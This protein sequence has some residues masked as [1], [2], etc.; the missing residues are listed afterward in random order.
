MEL[1]PEMGVSEGA[2][3]EEA[4]NFVHVNFEISMGRYLIIREEN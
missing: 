3:D 2:S 1:Y 4:F